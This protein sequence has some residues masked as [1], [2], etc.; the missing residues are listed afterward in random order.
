MTCENKGCDNE[1]REGYK[2]CYDCY[3]RHE[4]TSSG[5]Q[6]HED[7]IVDQLMKINANLGNL[8]KATKRE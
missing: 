2:F 8:V 6:W 3:K 5:K 1:T 4:A 7:P